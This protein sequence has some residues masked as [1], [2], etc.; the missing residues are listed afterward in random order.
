MTWHKICIVGQRPTRS[1]IRCAAAC[2]SMVGHSLRSLLF[3]IN[4]RVVRGKYL[5]TAALQDAAC[6]RA[7]GFEFLTERHLTTSARPYCSA[8]L[9]PRLIEHQEP[10]AALLAISFIKL[11]C[12][13]EP[14][15]P[16]PTCSPG[17]AVHLVVPAG[18]L[19]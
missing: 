16:Q 13:T 11:V 14:A 10:S 18:R 6:I 8:S 12:Q 19:Y 9:L 17:D 15:H 7:Y 5:A 2:I 1:C 3:S 4:K